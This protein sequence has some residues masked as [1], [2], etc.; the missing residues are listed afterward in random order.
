MAGRTD[1]KSGKGPARGRPRSFDRDAALASAMRV[2]WQRGYEA[3]SVSDLTRAMGINAPSLYA[4]FGCKEALFG[5]AVELYQKTEG[6]AAGRALVDQPTARD[7]IH[8]M[9]RRYVAD[10][11]DPDKPAGCMIVLAAA[12]GTP[13]SAEVRD[14]LRRQ[15]QGAL[16]AIAARIRRG[17]K[18]GDVPA[19]TDPRRVAAFIATVLQGLSIQ[20]RDG[21]RRADLQAV[22]DGA[23]TAWDGLTGKK[24]R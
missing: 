21:A 1:T 13:D 7:A 23:M 12:V 18:E 17:M 11:T 16:D 20:A 24:S 5:E 10:Y 22:V 8:A 6:I 19:G 2:F 3:T 9:L 14:L 4:A 15:R